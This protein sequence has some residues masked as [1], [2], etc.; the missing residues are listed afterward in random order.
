MSN[1][2]LFS[3]PHHLHHPNLFFVNSSI[4]E[5]ILATNP[6]A[7]GGQQPPPTPTVPPGSAPAAPQQ[8]PPPKKWTEEEKSIIDTTLSLWARIVLPHVFNGETNYRKNFVQVASLMAD[9]ITSASVL[10]TMV[11]VTAKDIVSLSNKRKVR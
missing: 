10:E 9:Q 4:K 2:H 7:I 1:Y 6:N 11:Q 8:P 3:T 5:H